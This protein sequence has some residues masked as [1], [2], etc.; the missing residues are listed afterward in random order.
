MGVAEALS[1]ILKTHSFSTS[2]VEWCCC[3][4]AT[5]CDKNSENQILFGSCSSL[6][7]VK[8][9]ERDEKD[10]HDK[11]NKE[12]KEKENEGRKVRRNSISFDK[13]KNVCELLITALNNHKNNV[14]VI[15]QV[16]KAVRTLSNDQTE[17]IVKF[18]EENVVQIILKILKIHRGSEFICENIGW[19]LT[20]FTVPKTVN[21]SISVISTGVISGDQDGGLDFTTMA[22]HSYDD[23]N[24]INNMN[25]YD[26]N[27]DL[28]YKNINNWTLLVSCIEH[29]VIKG[30]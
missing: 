9:T 20:H 30:L 24:K 11:E 2:L 10:G 26:N 14:I 8:N 15:L 12:N 1:C 16:T 27:K 6:S 23:N 19:M 3:A 28:I 13:S 17:I 22:L 18:S 21:N 25:C 4:I 5:L 29:H 7:T